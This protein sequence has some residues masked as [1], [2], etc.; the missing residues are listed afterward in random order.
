MQGVARRSPCKA[1]Q[2]W[3][4]GRWSI[5]KPVGPSGSMQSVVQSIWC[6]T[7]MIGLSCTTIPRLQHTFC[8]VRTNRPFP[9]GVLRATEIS[10][11]SK[12]RTHAVAKLLELILWSVFCSEILVIAQ[13]SRPTSILSRKIPKSN[14]GNSIIEVS[15]PEQDLLLL[16]TGLLASSWTRHYTCF[17]RACAI[18]LTFPRLLIRPLKLLSNPYKPKLNKHVLDHRYHYRR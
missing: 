5:A 9:D 15:V 11:T 14:A 16:V 7:L 2:G 13:Y 17:F 4:S 18:G 3:P 12:T 10:S 6:A 1:A 8:F